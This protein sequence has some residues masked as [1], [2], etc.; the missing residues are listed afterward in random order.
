VAD[1]TMAPALVAN[2]LQA[3]LQPLH[4]AVL[5]AVQWL[6]LHH[7]NNCSHLIGCSCSCAGITVDPSISSFVDVLE[8]NWGQPP[9]WIEWLTPWC[10]R[11]PKPQDATSND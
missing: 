5:A 4:F 3:E 6:L 1:I 7:C 8:T 2:L 11:R 9:E 10:F